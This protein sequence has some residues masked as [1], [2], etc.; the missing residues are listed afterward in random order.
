MF[1]D[2]VLPNLKGVESCI[3][4]TSTQFVATSGIAPTRATAR[5]GAEFGQCSGIIGAKTA[6]LIKGYRPLTEF[7]SPRLVRKA[8]ALGRRLVHDIQRPDTAFDLKAVWINF[9]RGLL[10]RFLVYRYPD[11]FGG[12]IRIQ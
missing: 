6:S 9:L 5:A 4:T 2:R 1:F 12:A 8:R 11:E 10:N 7:Y 3:C